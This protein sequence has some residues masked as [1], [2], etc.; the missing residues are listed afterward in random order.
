MGGDINTYR[1]VRKNSHG[2]RGLKLNPRK[3]SVQ[4]LRVKFLYLFRVFNGSWRSSYGNI[5]RSLKKNIIDCRSSKNKVR[6]QA[7]Y[8]MY[9]GRND[10]KLKSFSRS[11]SF[12]AEAI[13]DCVDFIKRNSLSL[14]EKPVLGHQ[15]SSEKV[16]MPTN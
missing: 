3:F 12:Y 13:A 14:E 4:R 1:I 8:A 6:K 9:G 5:L 11:N 7:D 16:E 10:F 15:G 2:M